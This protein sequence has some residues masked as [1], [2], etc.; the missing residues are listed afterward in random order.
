MLGVQCTSK[1]RDPFTGRDSKKSEYIQISG[2]DRCW[3]RMENC[4][5]KSPLDSSGWKEPEESVWSVV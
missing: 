4:M 5:Q 1:H 3:R 2:I